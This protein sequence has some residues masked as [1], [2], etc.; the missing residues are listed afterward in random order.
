MIRVQVELK[1]FLCRSA[2]QQ[3]SGGIV[4]VEVPEGAV[5]GDVLET[6]GVSESH[7]GLMLISGKRARLTSCLADGDVLVIFPVVAGG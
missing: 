5:I 7:A 1:G 4:S 6:V 2:S 3:N